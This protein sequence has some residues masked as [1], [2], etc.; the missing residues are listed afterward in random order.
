MRDKDEIK[1]YDELKKT[2]NEKNETIEKLRWQIKR[3]RLTLKELKTE[4]NYD[5]ME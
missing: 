1:Y 2:I 4:G 3:I 5:D